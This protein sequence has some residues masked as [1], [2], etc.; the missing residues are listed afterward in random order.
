MTDNKK[1]TLEEIKARVRVVCI[2]KGIKMARI[3]E[4]VQNGAKTVEEV[5]KATGSG[6][7]GCGATRCRPVIEEILRNGGRPLTS[8]FP[9]AVTDDDDSDGA[10]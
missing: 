9:S 3:C 7:G 2:C 8:Q 5:N 6:N 10:F 4:A 1:L